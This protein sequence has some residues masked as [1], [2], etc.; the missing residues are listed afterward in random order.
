MTHV[1][2]FENHSGESSN[3]IKWET[4]KKHVANQLRN[5]LQP[6]DII[7]KE[8][9]KILTYL[10][11]R[12]INNEKELTFTQT[13]DV[14]KEV[15]NDLISIVDNWD[16]RMCDKLIELYPK[17]VPSFVKNKKYKAELTDDGWI[18]VKT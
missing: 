12:R 16:I 13:W 2:T 8:A 9:G 5:L 18:L 11:K 6:R 14:F 4:I 15:K 17:G 10:V 1:K 3:S 7:I